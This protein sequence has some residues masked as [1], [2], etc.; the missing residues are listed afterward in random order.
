[1]DYEL[2]INVLQV[3]NISIKQCAKVKSWS[4]K[5][6]KYFKWKLS[7]EWFR[8][9]SSNDSKWQCTRS[10]SNKL[11]KKYT[12]SI[13]T[14]LKDKKIQKGEQKR[15]W[16]RKRL[17]IP[18]ASWILCNIERCINYKK[19]THL[20]SSWTSKRF[21]FFFKCIEFKV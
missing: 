13:N 7:N 20:N 1:M 17:N 12:W 9:K 3:K 11:I 10:T 15:K 21:D 18:L 2:I 5:K 14:R 16:E 6:V 19:I 4:K 8:K